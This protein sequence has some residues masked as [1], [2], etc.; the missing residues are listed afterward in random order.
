MTTHGPWDVIVAGLG[1][2]GASALHALAMRG[3][4][5]LGLDR[6][7]PPHALGS[8][9]G[10]SR[11]IR[12]AYFED[13]RYVPLVQHAYTR[14][15]ALEAAT[16]ASLLR[17]TGGLMIGPPDGPLVRGALASARLHGLPHE[18]LDAGEVMARVPAFHLPEQHA[19][20]FE[21]RAGMLDPER[22][23]AATLAEAQRLGAQVAT[24]QPVLDWSAE[25]DAVSVATPSGRHHARRLV[26]A[27]GPWMAGPLLRGVLPLTVERN[28]L[29]WFS[30]PR[31]T[32]AFDARRFPVFLHEFEAGRYWYGFPDTGDGVKV[33]LHGG[34]AP[35]DADSLPRTVREPEINYM[36]A[37]LTRHLPAAAG[38]LREAVVCPYTNTPDGHF[39]LDHHPD[40]AS[41]ILA[42]PC[43]GHGFKFAP[44]VG[45]LIADLALDQPSRF[46]RSLF[47]AKRFPRA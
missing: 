7:A 4:R 24:A 41:V 20:V 28:V 19:A 42:S 43:S 17:E 13:P 6:H 31:P 30:P 38:A 5:V 47:A 25:G 10:R 14:W 2:A 34:G 32:D 3:A 35:S 22:A 18:R 39:V 29:F 45:E 36:S 12:E 8:S 21:P 23:I 15:R 16:G 40:H 1:A 27:L 46:D 11:I 9:H 33:A 44:A 26:L 37:L